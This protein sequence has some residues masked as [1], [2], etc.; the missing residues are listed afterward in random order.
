MK[1]NNIPVGWRPANR[2]ES[3]KQ[4]RCGRIYSGDGWGRLERV[5]L[6]EMPRDGGPPFYELRNCQCKSTLAIE[7]SDERELLMPARFPI[8]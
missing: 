2:C 6:Q 5:G 3:I 8:R 7:M 1:T 4:C